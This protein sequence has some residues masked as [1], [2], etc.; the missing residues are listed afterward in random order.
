MQNEIYGCEM[1]ALYERDD[2]TDL[3]GDSRL[4]GVSMFGSDP[5]AN[6]YEREDVPLGSQPHEAV[7]R[8]PF[9]PFLYTSLNKIEKFLVPI[10]EAEVTID[11]L[12][13]CAFLE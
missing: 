10:V 4:D 13:V 12:L 3:D 2:S 11:S 6:I 1:R 8:L 9:H 7:G 5:K